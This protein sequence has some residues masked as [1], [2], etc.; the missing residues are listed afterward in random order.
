MNGLRQEEEEAEQR[1][2]KGRRRGSA[3]RG[4]KEQG[5]SPLPE[6]ARLWGRTRQ[7]MAVQSCTAD[8]V[9]LRRSF[10][11]ALLLLLLLQC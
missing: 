5:G 8:G 1:R 2:E 11:I 10:L 4:S 7:P 6:P 3:A 9:R